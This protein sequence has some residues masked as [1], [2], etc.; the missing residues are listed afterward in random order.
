M[1]VKVLNL[2][3]LFFISSILLIVAVHDL[4]AADEI[5][6]P[7]ILSIGGQLGYQARDNNRCEGLYEARTSSEF[8]LLSFV[9]KME[10]IPIDSPSTIKVLVP[11]FT[12]S[13]GNIASIRVRALHQNTYYQLDTRASSGTSF[14]WP[15]APVLDKVGLSIQDLG[16]L[17]WFPDPRGRVVLPLELLGSK[18]E[19]GMNLKASLVVRSPLPLEWVKWRI[20]QEQGPQKGA[21]SWKDAG[22]RMIAPGQPIHVDVPLEGDGNIN[23]IDIYAKPVKRDTPER[24]SARIQD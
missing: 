20:Y 12:H 8:E 6:D 13:T 22:M 4:D 23:I 1:R 3:N 24:L 9:K 21:V 14:S 15:S 11:N 17:A 18:G 16:F 19:T 7:S 5:C 2:I 10:V